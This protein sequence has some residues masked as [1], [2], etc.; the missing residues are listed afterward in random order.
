MKNLLLILLTITLFSCG[1]EA[2]EAE[3]NPNEELAE[4][5]W[6]APDEI[7]DYLYSGE[8]LQYIEFLDA[9]NAQY[10]QTNNGS[11]RNSEQG[12]FTYEPPFVTI[13]LED[14]ELEFEITGSLMVS[15]HQKTTTGDFLTYTKQ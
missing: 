8:N 3:V 9:E 10:Y 2:P 7:A 5:K 6:E 13:F 4:T 14:K 15:T 11:V 1:E 12:T